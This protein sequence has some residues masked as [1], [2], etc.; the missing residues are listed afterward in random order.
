MS[1]LAADP[2]LLVGFS[3]MLAGMGAETVAAVAPANAP[4]LAAARCAQVKI[5]DLEDLEQA[6]RAGSAEVLIGNSHAAHT[7]E[8]LG[9]PLLRAGFPQ[10]DLVGGY[11]RTWIGYQG[12]RSTLF[13]LANILLRLE[14][15]EIHPYRSRL[16]PRPEEGRITPARRGLRPW[17]RSAYHA[18]TPATGNRDATATTT[19][20]DDL[21]SRRHGVRTG[22]QG[23]LRQL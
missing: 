14:R 9:I 23:G 16:S 1:P 17:V 8:R 6:A 7:A 3:Q 11:Q 18:G 12:T 13:E 15:G 21:R 22:G 2:D 5:G 19:E 10:Y 4:A 20:S